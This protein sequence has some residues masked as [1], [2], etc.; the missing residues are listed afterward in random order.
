M[1][2]LFAYA[3][4]LGYLLV[5]LA[6]LGA[7]TAGFVFVVGLCG[8]LFALWERRWFDGFAYLSA[9]LVCGALLLPLL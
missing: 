3:L 7:L 2:L 1:F 6:V 8:G 5:I 4:V 9:A